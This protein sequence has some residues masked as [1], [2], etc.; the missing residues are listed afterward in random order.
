[1]TKNHSIRMLSV[2]MALLLA[3]CIASTTAAKGAPPQKVT[4]W[5]KLMVS[6]QSNGYADTSLTYYSSD[7]NGPLMREDL[8]N[9]K[10]TQDLLAPHGMRG[11]FWVSYK[12]TF[13]LAFNAL[14]RL[15]RLRSRQIG[16]AK[17]RELAGWPLDLHPFPFSPYFNF[18]PKPLFRAG[19]TAQSIASLKKVGTDVFEGHRC[20]VL[21]ERAKDLGDTSK[22]VKQFWWDEQTHFIWK[23]TDTTYP[24]VHSP[25]PPSRSV[26]YVKWVHPMKRSP[27]EVFRFP[28]SAHVVAPGILGDLPVPPGGIKIKTIPGGNPYIGASL[29]PMI[30][31]LERV[32]GTKNEVKVIRPKGSPKY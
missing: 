23:E 6:Q 20:L 30:K 32:K 19:K 13:G 15:V 7:A 31:H 18:G 17:V 1:M 14:V 2:G 27:S 21:Q 12:N 11:L 16:Y 10:F 9:G 8:E 24:S 25:N 28:A 26:D 5:K 22:M 4:Y 3:A 29:A